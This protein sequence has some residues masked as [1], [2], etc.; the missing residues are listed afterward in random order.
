EC[1]ITYHRRMAKEERKL[2]REHGGVVPRKTLMNITPGGCE[3]CLECTKATARPGLTAGD[4]DYGRKI[5]TDLTWGGHDGACEG[6]RTSNDKAKGHS[7]RAPC[8]GVRTTLSRRK[9]YSLQKMD[10]KKLPDPPMVNDMSKP[11]SAWRV[12]M[13]GVGGMGIGIVGAILVRAGH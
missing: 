4:T 2:A 11:G 13:A 3:G 10:L 8:E 5:D 12:H 1:G 9:R 6:G 7:P